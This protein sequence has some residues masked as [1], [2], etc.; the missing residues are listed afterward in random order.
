MTA[1]PAPVSPPADSKEQTHGGTGIA[2]KRR[3]VKVYVDDVEYQHIA[4]YAARANRFR[5]DYMR[6]I[7]LGHPVRSVWH[8]A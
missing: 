2:R 7:V 1:A 5:S 4:D 3:V 8:R 6:Q